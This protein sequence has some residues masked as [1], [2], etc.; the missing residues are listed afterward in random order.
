MS[1]YTFVTEIYEI[2]MCMTW[3]NDCRF[4]VRK[5]EVR[6]EFMTDK[7]KRYMWYASK[8][9]REDSRDK[10]HRW[11]DKNWTRGDRR[12]VVRIH[13]IK[14]CVKTREHMWYHSKTSR[15]DSRERQRKAKNWSREDK[16]GR[17]IHESWSVSKRMRAASGHED[18]RE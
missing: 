18:I 3:M 14:Q 12:M 17:D 15:Q 10:R 9:S 2:Y 5:N 4:R 7:V 1:E 16:P 13:G 11:C 8:T 6:R